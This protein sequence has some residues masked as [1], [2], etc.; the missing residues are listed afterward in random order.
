MAP[1][2]YGMDV[3]Q[4]LAHVDENTIGVVPTLGV[5]YT[6]RTSRSEPWPRCSTI[7]RPRAV[8]TSTSTSTPP[9]AGS[10]PLLRARPGVGLP[11]PPGEVDQRLGPQ[12]RAGALGV[13]WVVWRDQAELPDELVFHVNYLG[14]DMP[15]FQLNFSGP[16]VRSSPSTT[17]SS[18]SAAR[19]YRK[20][21][22]ACYGRRRAGRGRSPGSG[23]SRSSTTASRGR[24]SPS[25]SWTLREGS[26]PGYSLFDLADR[27]RRAAGS[28]R[29]HAHRVA[30]R[31]RRPAH[32][33][34][35]GRDAGPA[36]LLLEDLRRG[37]R[38]TSPAPDLGLDDARGGVGLQ[39][40]LTNLAERSIWS[41]TFSISE[42]GLKG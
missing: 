38:A 28:T 41:P 36:A 35:P 30:G 22:S 26:E 5:T 10:S 9:A 34:A 31:P 3:E 23:R 7:C 39:P 42:G 24:A 17:S 4:M 27:L 8:S 20:V 11:P 15:T 25:V 6:G 33:G 16:R 13:G 2:R 37:H 29:L 19:G 40:P 18:A 32:P 12:V 1:G 14:G 21:Q